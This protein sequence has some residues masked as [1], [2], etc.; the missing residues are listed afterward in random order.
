MVKIYRIFSY[1][2]IVSGIIHIGFT[3]VFYSSLSIN[4]IWF[5]GTGLAVC[6]LGLLNLSD[7]ISEDNIVLRISI[8][9]N[10]LFFIFSIS[11]AIA[12]NE[13]HAYLFIL[14]IFGLLIGSVFRHSNL[15][16]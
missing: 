5:I 9:S 2:T 13:P 1:L 8:V 3:P 15:K 7:L 6:F 16:N 11:C 4:A 10:I 12:V 14:I